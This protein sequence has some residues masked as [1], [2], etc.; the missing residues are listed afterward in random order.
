MLLHGARYF[1]DDAFPLAVHRVAVGEPVAMHGHDFHELVITVRGSASHC[2]ERGDEQCSRRLAPGDVFVLAPNERHAYDEPKGLEVVNCLFRPSCLDARMDELVAIDGLHDL[3]VVEPLC[4]HKP[5]GERLRLAPASR[6]SVVAECEALEL[7]LQQTASGYR[8]VAINRFMTV[9]I[10]LARD[11]VQAGPGQRAALDGQHAAVAD[12]IALIE[13][14]HG[15]E[16]RLEDIAREAHLSP[17]Y[18]SQLFHQQTGQSPWDYLTQ[19]RI[20]R[21]KDL[22]RTTDRSI[23]EIAFAVGFN[24]S[25]YFARVFKTR[26]GQTPLKWRKGC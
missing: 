12:A 8:S 15:T 11:W 20:E 7:E 4:R 18:L 1:H 24:D 23:T 25:S 21:A 10:L 13:A 2:I 14:Q 6:R 17:H 19:V 9:L 16:L 3:L 22:L 26:E 5:G